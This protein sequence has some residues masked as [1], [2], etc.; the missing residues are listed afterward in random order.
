M[1][2]WSVDLVEVHDAYVD[3][4]RQSLW[5]DRHRLPISVTLRANSAYATLLY[6][7]RKK[8]WIKAASVWMVVLK[9]VL[10]GMVAG[11][12]DLDILLDPFFLPATPTRQLT[13]WYPHVEDRGP[14][15]GLL[16]ALQI[17]D[18]ADPWRIFYRKRLQEH[19]AFTIPRLPGKLCPTKIPEVCFLTSFPHLCRKLMIPFRFVIP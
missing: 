19:P 7:V 11:H 6:N 15:A 10:Q 14:Q 2:G 8:R 1:A 3:A 9:K 18:D 17:A 12:C 13:L 4:S 5:E 16:E